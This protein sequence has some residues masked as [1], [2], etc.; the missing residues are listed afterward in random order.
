LNQKFIIE[1]QYAH[2]LFIVKS[3]FQEIDGDLDM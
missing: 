2:N 3:T 1:N